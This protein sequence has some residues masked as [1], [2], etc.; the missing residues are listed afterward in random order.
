[1]VMS[2]LRE[3]RKHPKQL[4]VRRAEASS[5]AL[6]SFPIKS[7]LLSL[8]LSTV[9]LLI[10]GVTEELSVNNLS[11]SRWGEGFQFQLHGRVIPRWIPL[12]A[13]C[14][15]SWWQHKCPCPDGASKDRLR[16]ETAALLRSVIRATWG[17]D[18]PFQSLFW[19]CSTLHPWLNPPAIVP[20]SL[21][22]PGYC[23][24][25]LQSG[26]A[27]CHLTVVISIKKGSSHSDLDWRASNFGTVLT[28]PGGC[29]FTC[30]SI[31]CSC[32]I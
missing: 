28:A 31:T 14:P 2:C 12:H 1:M 21:C 13:F 15:H 19:C 9:L 29:G 24:D 30:H 22:F 20:V 27:S 3:V 11:P 4:L 25:L 23:A 8:S 17:A 26:F 7:P 16:C 5:V 6:L 10:G 18:R 32:N